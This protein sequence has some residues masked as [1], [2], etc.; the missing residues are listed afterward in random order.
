MTL[1]YT[2]RTHWLTCFT[3]T[4]KIHSF[5]FKSVLNLIETVFLSMKLFLQKVV[6]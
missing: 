1:N 5:A 4:S 2:L 6:P 3:T